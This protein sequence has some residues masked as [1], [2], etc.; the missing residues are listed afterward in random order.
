MEELIYN[1]IISFNNESIISH[2]LK[3]SFVEN[4]ELI[5][6]CDLGKIMI[7]GKSV[8]VLGNKKRIHE[9]KV[10]IKDSLELENED[11]VIIDDIINTGTTMSAAISA[12][13]HKHNVYCITVHPILA[14]NA[15]KLLE[16]KAKV[17]STNT[18]THHTNQIDIA[19]LI[20]DHIKGL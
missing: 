9:H 17:I 13:Q 1:H 6:I 11:A 19:P 2:T 5:L 8:E 7:K 18:I 3:N 16:K 10:E 20:A 12:L 15:E 14:G 4:G